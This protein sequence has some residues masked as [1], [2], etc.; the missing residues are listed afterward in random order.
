[1][2]SLLGILAVSAS[3]PLVPYLA[4]G[5]IA[6]AVV[7]WILVSVL[8]PAIPNRSCP[9]CKGPGLVKL[10]RG[11]PGVRC[12]LCGFRDEDMHVAYLDEW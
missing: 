4:V 7:A 9:R 3:W 11:E 5:A 12:E 10:R 6:V 8:S 1:V 2:L